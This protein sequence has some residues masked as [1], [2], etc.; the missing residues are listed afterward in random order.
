[1]TIQYMAAEIWVTYVKKNVEACGRPCA[2]T[3]AIDVGLFNKDCNEAMI[4]DERVTT[5]NEC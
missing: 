4:P 5:K 2:K 1:M 3:D